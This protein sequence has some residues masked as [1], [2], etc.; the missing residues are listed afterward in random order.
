VS[1]ARLIVEDNNPLIFEPFSY[2]CLVLAV[3]LVV[4]HLELN[5]NL[6]AFLGIEVTPDSH[7]IRFNALQLFPIR[8]NFVIRGLLD[9]IQFSFRTAIDP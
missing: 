1:K 8:P 3:G 2:L 5:A 7:V 4:A 9:W 6:L